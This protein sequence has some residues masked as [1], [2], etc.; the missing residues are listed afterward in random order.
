MVIVFSAGLE[1]IHIRDF[2]WRWGQTSHRM[3]VFTGR[4]NKNH[5]FISSLYLIKTPYLFFSFTWR[6][7]L[8]QRSGRDLMVN[9][10]RILEAGRQEGSD[11]YRMFEDQFFFQL[12]KSVVLSCKIYIIFFI[13]SA[14]PTLFWA[15]AGTKEQKRFI[16]RHF[17]RNKEGSCAHGVFL[18]DV[19]HSTWERVERDVGLSSRRKQRFVED[20][21]AGF[22]TGSLWVCKTE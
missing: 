14:Q 19:T 12:P 13:I 17:M 20:G 1:L 10:D 7:Y 4:G 21:R 11:L 15:L 2:V 3:C 6:L 16:F 5:F 9:T 22:Y 8:A 18:R